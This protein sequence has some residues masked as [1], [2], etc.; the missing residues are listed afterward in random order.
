[1]MNPIEMVRSGRAQILISQ[2]LTA[3][4]KLRRKQAEPEARDNN[5]SERELQREKYIYPGR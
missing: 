5:K 2:S 1:M 3:H 4:Q